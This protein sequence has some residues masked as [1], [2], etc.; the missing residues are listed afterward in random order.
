[1]RREDCVLDKLAGKFGCLEGKGIVARERRIFLEVPGDI[2]PEVIGYV[3]AELGFTQLCTITGSDLV[4]YF[5]FIYHL[6]CSDGIIL[7]LKLNS[8]K[9]NPVIYTVTGIFNGAVFY[10]RELEDMLG[11]K[12]E[13]LPKGRRYPLPDDWPEGSYPLRKDW[14]PYMIPQ[15]Q[16]RR[17]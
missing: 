16:S 9:E 17:L 15:I 5:Q 3:A 12:V 11:V 14:K 2:F 7:N 13:G 6:A 10:E 8:P 1:L 4:D